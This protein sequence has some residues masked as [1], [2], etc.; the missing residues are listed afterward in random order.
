MASYVE[1]DKVIWLE[2]AN[3]TS[4]T[5]VVVDRCLHY[6]GNAQCLQTSTRKRLVVRAH[7][8]RYSIRLGPLWERWAVAREID[9]SRRLFF[10]PG[11]PPRQRQE[12]TI[13]SVL[14][15][16]LGQLKREEIS[17]ALGEGRRTGPKRKKKGRIK[18]ESYRSTLFFLLFL[19]PFFLI[20]SLSIDREKSRQ[21]KRIYL[22]VTFV[23]N[24]VL[25][26][27]SPSWRTRQAK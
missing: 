7:R 27:R 19:M 22:D 16:V 8:K 13:E 2:D 14:Q 11:R 26:F 10:K 4:T 5:K 21:K 12:S 25:T 15:S 17:C 18:R 1:V 23:L 6:I 20:L 9:S 24:S 3:K